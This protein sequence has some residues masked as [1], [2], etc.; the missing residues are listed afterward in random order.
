MTD[1]K[2]LDSKG[3]ELVKPPLMYD[4]AIVDDTFN[5]IAKECHGLREVDSRKM[6]LP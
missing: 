6:F 1:T 3:N 4:D 2:I 5:V